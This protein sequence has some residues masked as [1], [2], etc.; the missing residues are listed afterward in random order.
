MGLRLFFC[1]LMLVHAT[2]S[3]GYSFYQLDQQL[4]NSP[5]KLAKKP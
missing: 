4:F 1:I 5:D 2:K 3:Q